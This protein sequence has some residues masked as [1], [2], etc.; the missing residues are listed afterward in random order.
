MK[1]NEAKQKYKGEWLAF[2]VKK[3]DKRG[4]LEGKLLIHTKDKR[5]L[6]QDL[7]KTRVKK[8][9]ITYAGPAVKPGYAVIFY[10]K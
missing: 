8:A 4:R 5:E 3:E 7:R 6:H 9:Y 10:E 1:L 2:Q